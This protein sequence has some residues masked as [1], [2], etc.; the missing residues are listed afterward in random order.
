MNIK[1]VEVKSVLVKTKLPVGDF[2]INPYIGCQH[3][4]FYCYARFMKR[5]TN[6]EEAWGSF[7]DIKINSPEILKQQLLKFNNCK[8]KYHVCL[9]SVTDPYQQ[10][11]KKYKLTRDILKTFINYPC[12]DIEIIT[13]SDLILRD[14]DILKKLK[15]VNV[16]FSISILDDNKAKFIEPLAS[17][18]SKRIKALAKIH[19]AKI[20]TSAFISPILPKIT[21]FKD[22]FKALDGKVDEVFGETL[23]PKGANF[24]SLSK[25]LKV[26]FPGLLPEYNK[27]FFTDFLKSYLSK[28]KKDFYA[29]ASKFNLPVWGFF[30]H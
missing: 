5:F 28:T 6:H 9:S 21:N 20:K 12:F 30:T 16:V 4:C 17:L 1:K 2:V 27:I 24:T 14:M 25:V 3:G 22:L 19:Q 26:R 29:E 23:N 8:K 7:V 10:V 15:N 11:E 18:P 13:K